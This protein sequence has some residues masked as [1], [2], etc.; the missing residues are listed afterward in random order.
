MRYTGSKIICSTR[1]IGNIDRLNG[2]S[3]F[4]IFVNTR[5]QSVHGVKMSMK[6]PINMS[7]FPFKNNDPR[8]YPNSGVHMKLIIRVV[9]VNLTFLKL[10]FNLDNGTSRN[11]P[12]SIRHR[13]MLIKLLVLSAISCMLENINPIITAE[14]IIRG[15]SFSIN[16]IF[17]PLFRYS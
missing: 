12:K 4:A 1:L 13:N 10:F 6:N 16:S 8:K 14:N 11:S 15:S 2:R 7:M 9:D 3:P 5:Y 17:T